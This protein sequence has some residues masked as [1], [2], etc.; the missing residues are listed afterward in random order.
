MTDTPKPNYAHWLIDEASGLKYLTE[1][2]SLR[3]IYRH[4][5]CEICGIVTDSYG[6]APVKGCYTG[7]TF[8]APEHRERN[9]N[10]EAA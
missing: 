9:D 10:E 7:C 4:P 1:V 2:G 5:P 6:T 8:C 3:R